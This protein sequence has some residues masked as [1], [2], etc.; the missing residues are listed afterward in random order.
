M[1]HGSDEWLTI[2]VLVSDYLCPNTNFISYK[3]Y[4]WSLLCFISPYYLGKNLKKSLTQRKPSVLAFI[5]INSHRMYTI[6]VSWRSSL[7]YWLWHVFIHSLHLETKANSG[8]F[9]TGTIW[10][11]ML[12]F[13]SIWF[14][15][16]NFPKVPFSHWFLQ[17]SWLEL[18]FCF[19]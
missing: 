6:E 16:N 5:S 12:L 2:W 1:G 18:Q 19:L 8:I 10:G 15:C 13:L 4:D 14:Y 11:R 9:R 17:Y 7:L 3:L